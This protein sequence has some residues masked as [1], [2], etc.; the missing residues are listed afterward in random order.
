MSHDDFAVEPI[1]GL[2]ERPPEGE[3]ILWQGRPDTLA[4]AKDAFAI[5]WVAGYFA[6]LAAWRGV[7]AA[8]FG[9]T[10]EIIAAMGWMVALGLLA[11]GL[12]YLAA[13]VQA[14]STI[15]TITNRRVA[16]RIGAALTLTLNLPF[17]QLETAGL[18]LNRNGTGT[19]ALT[20][21]PGTQ[22]SYLICW[23][24]VRPWRISR[25]EPALRS[26][27][28]AEAIAQKL[29]QAAE[30]RISEPELAMSAPAAVPAE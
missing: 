7:V 17:R 18:A 13:L 1:P 23:P 19:I 28:N 15:Y 12:L 30:T 26:I 29:A 10:P 4:L 22:I 27:P 21:K 14:R 25:V 5:H 16:L 2:P 3:E 20:M 24:H 8:E 11:C 9:G 6:I